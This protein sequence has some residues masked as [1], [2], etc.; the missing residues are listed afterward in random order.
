MMSWCSTR[1]ERDTE[2]TWGTR[3]KRTMLL[4]AKGCHVVALWWQEQGEGDKAQGSRPGNSHTQGNVER[5]DQRTPVVVGGRTPRAA[6]A[7][8][9]RQ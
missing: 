7:E 9:Q 6:V 3:R 8:G 2:G 5:W 1:L 4:A